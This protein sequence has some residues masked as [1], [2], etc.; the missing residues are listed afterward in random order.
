VLHCVRRASVKV[1]KCTS[2]ENLGTSKETRKENAHNT[3]QRA[4]QCQFQY[5][6]TC[7]Q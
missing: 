1:V 7:R 3:Q 2:K 4:E 5:H 6:S